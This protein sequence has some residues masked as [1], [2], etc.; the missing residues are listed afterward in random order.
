[1]VPDSPEAGSPT[2]SC[3]HTADE[4]AAQFV[5]GRDTSSTHNT[6]PVRTALLDPDDVKVLCKF[7]I[8]RQEE[9]V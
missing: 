4:S 6:V 7:R 9:I 5:S 1:M 2:P 3:A 8:C